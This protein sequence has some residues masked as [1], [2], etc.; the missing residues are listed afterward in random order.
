M[1]PLSND[2]KKFITQ[3]LGDISKG[4][5]LA[6]VLEVKPNDYWQILG[7]TFVSLLIFFIAL[8]YQKE[9]KL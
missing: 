7:K 9:G 2:Q 8:N 3:F 4:I 1:N 6:T 5:F